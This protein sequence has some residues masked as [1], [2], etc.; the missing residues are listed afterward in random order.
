MEER[1]RLLASSGTEK[2]PIENRLL[3][4]TLGNVFPAFNLLKSG[5]DQI[6]KYRDNNN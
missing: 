3:K 4:T 6:Q 5:I 2:E 1:D